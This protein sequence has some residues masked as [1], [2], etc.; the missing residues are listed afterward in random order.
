MSG[1]LQVDTIQSA[2]GSNGISISNMR[3]RCIQRVSYTYRSGYWRGN[4]TY[5]WVPGAYVEFQPLRGDTRLYMSFSVP[6][7]DYGS[8]HMIMHWIM[9]VDDQEQMRFSRGGHHV[10]NAHVFEWDVNSWGQGI[11]R[12]GFKARSYSEGNHNAH[13]YMARYWNGGGNSFRLPGQL[14]VEE[15]TVV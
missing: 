1:Q 5:Y 3:R 7:R 15:Y 10:E 13:L 14:R 11:R 12:V 6:T 4:N 8:A 2:N 9:Y